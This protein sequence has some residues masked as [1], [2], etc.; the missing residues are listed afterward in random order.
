M[1]HVVGVH[2]VGG[3]GGVKAEL[4]FDLTVS[5]VARLPQE[6]ESVRFFGPGLISAEPTDL[7]P[8]TRLILPPPT[9]LPP[10]CV[11]CV[12]L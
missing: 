9:Q 5:E 7:F 12:R 8:S 4:A 1:G 6:A 10:A 11:H 3:G 2:G